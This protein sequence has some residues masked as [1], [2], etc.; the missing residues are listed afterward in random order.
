MAGNHEDE[1]CGLGH[2]EVCRLGSHQR[3]AMVISRWT[4]N[5]HGTKLVELKGKP[6]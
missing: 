2:S 3:A 1:A 4:Q 6:L 5:C